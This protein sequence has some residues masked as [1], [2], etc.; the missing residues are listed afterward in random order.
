MKHHIIEA[1]EL[2][3]AIEYDEETDQLLDECDDLV[4]VFRC[5]AIAVVII[6]ILHHNFY[7]THPDGKVDTYTKKIIF[8]SMPEDWHNYLEEKR[9][10]K[11]DVEDLFGPE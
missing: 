8:T 7:D 9:S 3:Q 10:A 2:R 5:D 11:Q 1:N 4:D 6:P